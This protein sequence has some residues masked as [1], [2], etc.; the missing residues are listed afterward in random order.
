MNTCDPLICY[1]FT[2]SCDL[3]VSDCAFESL[4]LFS[5]Y[6][7]FYMSGLYTYQCMLHEIPD[8]REILEESYS[9]S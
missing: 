3:V 1:K 2:G 7:E 5:F 4:K 8:K 9:L 6:D